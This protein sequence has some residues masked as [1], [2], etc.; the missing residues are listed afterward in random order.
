LEQI[1]SLIKALEFASDGI[2]SFRGSIGSA[3]RT[4]IEFNKA[5]KD[6]GRILDAMVEEF[7]KA[8]NLFSQLIDPIQKL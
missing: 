5:K 4:T 3:P 7:Q 1:E 2:A 6:A 8:I